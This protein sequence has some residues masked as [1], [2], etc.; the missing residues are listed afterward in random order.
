MAQQDF[1]TQ[2]QVIPRL[3][4]EAICLLWKEHGKDLS[5]VKNPSG[6]RTYQ[7][8]S[9]EWN[10]VNSVFEVKTRY[11]GN[12]G[13]LLRTYPRYSKRFPKNGKHKDECYW[14]Y[15][16]S[17]EYGPAILYLGELGLADISGDQETN[18]KGSNSGGGGQL[19]NIV[20]FNL[21]PF[22]SSDLS[23]CLEHYELTLR[24]GWNPH[25]LA[26][27]RPSEN[28]QDSSSE[29][30]TGLLHNLPPFNT[31]FVG[32]KRARDLE[33]IHERIEDPNRTKQ[34]SVTG[35]GGLG[36]TTLAAQYAI[37]YIDH[38][39]GGCCFIEPS[40][41]S[42]RETTDDQ[43]EQA[44]IK[45]VNADRA[46]QIVSFALALGI[47][48][49]TTRSIPE[50]MLEVWRKL[51][52]RKTLFIVD[53]VKAASE[54]NKLIQHDKKNFIFLSTSRVQWLGTFIECINL[55]LP[56]L[57]DAIIQLKNFIDH[58]RV[59]RELDVV[60]E[61]LGDEVIGKLPLAVTLLGSFLAMDERS[62]VEPMANTL[63]RF[64]KARARLNL[65]EDE[66][67]KDGAR[68]TDSHRGLK[69]IFDLTWDRLDSATQQAAKLLAFFSP[70][71]VD[72]D[73]VDRS[74]ELGFMEKVCPD[75]NEVARNTIRTQLVV[76]SLITR[77]FLEE[78][79]N[80]YRYHSLIGDF[81][82]SKV[83][84]GDREHWL[85]FLENT[86]VNLTVKSA[87]T[88]ENDSLIDD[89]DCYRRRFKLLEQ[90]YL[91]PNLVENDLVGIFFQSLA[92][93]YQ[94]SG[95]LDQVI[96]VIKRAVTHAEERFGRCQ[97]CVYVFF[98]MAP[99]YTF[100]G[101]YNEA[102][103]LYKE[104]LQIM[105]QLV[106]GN[107]HR[108]IALV[109]NQ[110]SSLYRN[111]G[112]Y[113]EAV[114]R[115]VDALEMQKR[116]YGDAHP[117]IAATLNYLAKTY[118]EQGL[119]SKAEQFYKDCLVMEKRL[120]GD[121]HKNI[122]V[123]LD[124]LGLV[125]HHQRRYD[126]AEQFYE[127]SLEIK[128]DLPG[129][130]PDYLITLSHLA[131]LYVEQG[132]YDEAKY[133]YEISL[134]MQERLFGDE[135]PDI[136]TILCQLAD[137][138]SEQGKHCEAEQLYE[139][140]LRMQERLFGDEHPDI[141]NTT[142][143]RIGRLYLKQGRYS[144]A[145]LIYKEILMIQ[146]IFFQGDHP[147][148]ALN[149]NKIGE[150]YQKVGM[151]EDAE[152]VYKYSL[153]MQE[154]LFGSEH[155]DIAETLDGIAKVYRVQGRY[156]D[157]KH[158][159]E[160]SLEMRRRL[161]GDKHIGVTA[162]LEKLAGV[163]LNQGEY[164]EAE[165]LYK[166]SL[167]TW[168]QVGGDGHKNTIAT[169]I[170]LA[171]VYDYQGRYDEAEQLYKEAL[172][173]W[174]L[175]GGDGNPGFINSLNNNLAG[176]YISQGK[177]DEA[178]KLYRKTL[179]TIKHEY[180]EEHMSLASTLSGLADL[181][182]KIGKYGNAFELISEVGTLHIK[183]FRYSKAEQLYEKALKLA[184]KIL[185]D[186]NMAVSSYLF[187]LALTY[188][189]QERYDEAEQYYKKALSMEERLLTDKDS[190]SNI[191]EILDSLTGLYKKQ[192]KDKEAVRF[193]KHQIAERIVRRHIEEVER[194]CEGHNLQAAKQ[195]YFTGRIYEERSRLQEAEQ[196]FKRALA[197]V[198]ELHGDE[199]HYS[200]ELMGKIADIY[201]LQGL[202]DEAEKVRAAF[203]NL[204]RQEK[205]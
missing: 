101:K 32:K 150:I 6:R 198:R 189:E 200:E 9:S 21:G 136:A 85:S 17:P 204:P 37:Q 102:E 49:N 159:Y 128:R 27:E 148:I 140:A 75:F 175:T 13:K 181:Y 93:F 196:L 55:E 145:D 31:A 47:D 97:E 121:E 120:Y 142:R 163:Y 72:W 81:F 103:A 116:L 22:P 143:E 153:E 112:R 78:E 197:I 57:S 36:K 129:I 132:K 123:I 168:K 184:R 202:N 161:L 130:H 201:E 156:D 69:A 46:L 30:L 39:P 25:P 5:Q 74:L 195:L 183:Y 169:S 62:K 88:I 8:F 35:L 50:Q 106:G 104:I 24:E 38:Y 41:A 70:T 111:L 82:E 20:E 4:I 58:D 127:K 64:K 139:K 118:Y 48:I 1:R 192:G 18:L 2:K 109:F 68:V 188:E 60:E 99:F 98:G 124:Q 191:P 193:Y 76:H 174:K 157:A 147:D 26:P 133:H 115:N 158:L 172:D 61:I 190:G 173:M 28:T 187:C 12:F 14:L 166:R 54:L 119:Y 138:Y 100:Q 66:I 186:E 110:L 16:K 7:E 42:E 149:S 125:C 80:G 171:S 34:I 94:R 44:K 122:A 199:H 90:A 23:E 177:Y 11:T 59:D 146:S 65:M 162:D 152:R 155:L 126:E 117:D 79:Q 84:L 205:Q 96:S 178:E 92:C 165:S 167:E 15:A 67:T 154:R 45:Q 19:K 29:L 160:R 164:R 3:I 86:S 135:H 63:D 170:N 134:Q 182:L 105:E 10:E 194:D 33:R 83:V 107:E 176:T 180:S 114:Q 131:G 203:I 53:D 95:D 51:P 185:G 89:L 151:Y 141:A 108:N 40:P 144:D 56:E 137:M 87:P 71:F 77:A 52:D 179:E 113:D 91:E 73:T 43:E